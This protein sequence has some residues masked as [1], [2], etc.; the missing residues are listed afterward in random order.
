V[1]V[2]QV[3]RRRAEAISSVVAQAAGLLLLAATRAEQI[4]TAVMEL[5]MVPVE[6]LGKT[7]ALG[8]VMGLVEVLGK[9][10]ALGLVVGL[11]EVLEKVDLVMA[12]VRLEILAKRQMIVPMDIVL[13]I[14]AVLV[15]SVIFVI[16]QMI[17]RS[18]FV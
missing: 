15:K 6:M 8:L 9:V 3:H 12:P 18:T 7:E 5:A 2:L 1:E 10:E 14:P 11:V 4:I 17:V 13:V 16:V